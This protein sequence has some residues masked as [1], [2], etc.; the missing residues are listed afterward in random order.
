MSAPQHGY[1]LP[2]QLPPD[3]EA[4]IA[5]EH[6]ALIERYARHAERLVLAAIAV[7]AY[8]VWSGRI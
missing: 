1:P 7:F 8:L 6:R 5:R 3:V 4:R 2:P